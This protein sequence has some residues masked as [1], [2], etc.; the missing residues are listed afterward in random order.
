[1]ESDERVNHN[2]HGDEGEHS[3]TDF[4]NLVAEIEQTD[5]QTAK[6]DSEM[7]PR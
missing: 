5:G 6:D 4:A 3:C 1:M 7:E 2:G